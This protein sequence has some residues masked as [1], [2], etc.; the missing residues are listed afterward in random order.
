MNIPKYV[1]EIMSRSRYCYEFE[2]DDPRCGA[3]YT[4]KIE[5]ATAYTWAP[6]FCEEI[7]R[8]R[9]WVERQPGG[10]CY[11]IKTP[12]ETRHTMQTA[13]VTIFDP[14]MMHLEKFMEESST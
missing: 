3:G 12:R 4:L 6:T 2:R 1:Q 13:V 11:V 8:L 10:V 14:V 7:E 9:R 5:K